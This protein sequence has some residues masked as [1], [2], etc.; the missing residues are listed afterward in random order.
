MTASPHLYAL[1]LALVLRGACLVLPH[2]RTGSSPFYVQ[3]PSYPFLRIILSFLVPAFGSY[4]FSLGLNVVY[5]A[6]L[7]KTENDLL[8]IVR[9]ICLIKYYLSA[10]FCYSLPIPSAL[11]AFPLSLLSVEPLMLNKKADEGVYVGIMQRLAQAVVQ[12][13]NA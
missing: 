5:L 4:G 6:C 10:V 9:S 2:T 12:V 3:I 8:F 13:G 7:T 11:S 1:A